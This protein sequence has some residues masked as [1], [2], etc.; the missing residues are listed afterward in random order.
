[1]FQHYDNKLDMDFARRLCLSGIV[2]AAFTFV[3]VL[4][5]AGPISIL[6]GVMIS[7]FATLAIFCIAT[8][9][10]ADKLRLVPFP[11]LDVLSGELTPRQ[12]GQ[13]IEVIKHTA[14]ALP[15]SFTAASLWM[16]M[17]LEVTSYALPVPVLLISIPP[18]AVMLLIVNCHCETP[19][20]ALGRS[21]KSFV[22]VVVA[23][24]LIIPGIE[25]PAEVTIPV[26]TTSPR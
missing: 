15:L 24:F 4:W 13:A 17:L 18:A 1:M 20:E 6:F 3:F 11:L 2:A 21:A 26:T 14:H 25:R 12:R 7:S 10:I 23:M 16:L 9:V 8:A 22:I 5:L 19:G